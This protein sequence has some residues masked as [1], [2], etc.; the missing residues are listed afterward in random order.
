MIVCFLIKNYSF[1]TPLNLGENPSTLTEAFLYKI[2]QTSDPNDP[3][4]ADIGELNLINIL[5]DMFMAGSDTTSVTL[6]WAML[7]M[8]Q[9]PDVQTK[10]IYV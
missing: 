1:S 10:G 6:D 2:Q 7:F 5:V 4:Y 8:I 9:N 3:F